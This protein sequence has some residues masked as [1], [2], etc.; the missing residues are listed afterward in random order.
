MA[1]E[2]KE[3]SS[4]RSRIRWREANKSAR[5]AE[6]DATR[7]GESR[8]SSAESWEPPERVGGEHLRRRTAINAGSMAAREIEIKE[9]SRKIEE[10]T[11]NAEP[12]SETPGETG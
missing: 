9:R 12:C 4:C 8:P 6:E 2:A 11:R 5:E 3:L 7:C 10:T 1:M